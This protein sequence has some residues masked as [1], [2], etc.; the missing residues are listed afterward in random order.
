MSILKDLD[1]QYAKLHSEPLLRK[2]VIW[3]AAALLALGSAYWIATESTTQAPPAEGKP[4][5]ARQAPTPPTGALAAKE[6][7]ADLP[8]ANMKKEVLPS[9]P[10]TTLAA[11][12][13]EE[14]RNVSTAEQPVAPAT[15]NAGSARTSLADAE[16]PRPPQSRPNKAPPTP[17][18]KSEQAKHKPPANQTLAKNEKTPGS[19][20]RK[21]TERDIDIITAIVR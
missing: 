1:P 8:S 17:P 7:S 16:Y 11:T 13:R 12:I 21:S 6:A 3:G 19:N 15:A 14:P 5:P 18:R 4:S 10:A 9:T 20:G 2:P